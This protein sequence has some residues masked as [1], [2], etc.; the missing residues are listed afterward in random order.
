MN[1]DLFRQIA[2]IAVFAATLVV[3]AM[4]TS[5]ALG[6]QPTADISNAYPIYFVPANLTFSVWGVIYLGLAAFVI[7]QA[8]PAQR[9][10]PYLRRIGW[11]FVW[12]GLANAG[13]LVLFQ[14]EQFVASVPVM[15]ALLGLLIVIYRR[16]DI[17]RA[18]VP[19]GVRWFAQVPFS[20]Y[21]AWI[22]IATIANAAQAL[23]ASGYQS[24]LGLG[25]AAW[26]ALML[27]VGT[28]II[29]AVVYQGRGNIAYALT[30]IWAILGIVI[31][32]YETALVAGTAAAMIAVI[33]AILVFSLWRNRRPAPGTRPGDRALAGG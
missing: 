16:L 7:Y 29:S 2:V 18:D 19:R 25:G 15:V 32:Q 17:G 13:W 23:Y 22:T 1:K 26:A 33:V 12:S 30:T 8:L 4:A 5:G 31:K 6:G 11:P 9:T 27:V 24:L 20:V 10:D 3:N 21:L 28:G 14:H